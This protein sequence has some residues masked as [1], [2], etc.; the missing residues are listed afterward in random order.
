MKKISLQGICNII[1]LI[2]LI[3]FVIKTVINYFQYD[4]ML[5]SAPFYVWIITNAVF[6]LIPALL[7]FIVG[8]IIG[9]RRKHTYP[10]NE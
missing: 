8:C 4:V 9:K 3:V 6:I 10:E 5:N 7:I 2:L 1:S